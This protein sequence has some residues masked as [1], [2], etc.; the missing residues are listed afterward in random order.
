LWQVEPEA[1]ASAGL[2]VWAGYTYV[3]IDDL[4]VHVWVA[5]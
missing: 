2:V 5:D 1:M 4:W 3:N